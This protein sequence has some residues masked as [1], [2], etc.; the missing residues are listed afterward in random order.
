MAE[1]G[2]CSWSLQATSVPELK[3]LMRDVGGAVVQVGL[4]DP[5]HGSWE[6]GDGLIETFLDS[7]LT[8]SATMIGFP[9]EDYTSPATIQRTGGFSDPATREERLAIFR[10]AVD[11][12]KALGVDLI[13][14]HAGY[15][16]PSGNAARGDFLDCLGDAVSYAEENEIGVALETGQ[17]SADL[18]RRTLDEMSMDGLGVNFDPANMILY[19]EGDPIDAV[20]LLGPDIFH[21]HFKDATPPA[22]PGEWGTEVPLGEG[23]VGMASYLEVL[24][25]VGYDGPLIVEREVGTQEQRVAD[26]RQGVH[27]LRRLL[28]ER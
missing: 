16:P 6:E 12:T 21:V 22:A 24:A 1:I 14:C 15:I 4:G 17:E 18:L 3:T 11:Q 2:V 9:G 7:G 27:T 26:I 19:D 8:I 23:H 25:A 28:T 5:T 10:H 13:S 20:K